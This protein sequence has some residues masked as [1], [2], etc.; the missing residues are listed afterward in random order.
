M[1]KSLNN[2]YNY[3]K[4]HKIFTINNSNNLNPLLEEK[5]LKKIE[6]E[7]GGELNG[8]RIKYEFANTYQLLFE[9]TTDCNLKCKYCAYG[10]LYDNYGIRDKHFLSFQKAKNLIDFYL[11]LRNSSLYQSFNKP[12]GIGFYGG[13]PL[14]NFKIINEIINYVKNIIPNC[15]FHMTTNGTLLN[16]YM[17]YLVEKNF[18]LMISL[19]GNKTNNSYRVYRNGFP[20]FLKIVNNVKALQLKYPNYFQTN[21]TFNTVLHNR[22]S[23]SEIFAFFKKEFNKI[24]KISELSPVGIRDDKKQIYFRKFQTVNKSINLANN[25]QEIIE[26][27]DVDVP[28]RK[29]LSNFLFD[30]SGNVFKTYNDL[31]KDQNT[32]VK[33]PTAT[34]EPFSRKIFLSAE[35]KLYPCERIG[36]LF[37]YGEATESIIDIDFEKIAAR[38]NTYYK[39]IKTQCFK[40]GL[41][42]VCTKCLLQLIS[43]DDNPNCDSMIIQDDLFQKTLAIQLSYLEKQPHLFK[44]IWENYN[45]E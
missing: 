6:D 41:I 24:P 43:K 42:S 35:G 21:V 34:C 39:K 36:Q 9:T 1:E 2:E 14:L 28:R 22:N 16:K 38:H 5:G 44:H 19:D 11:K 3:S 8:N 13:E 27:L 15:S 33:F 32:I 20:S 37:A 26:A 12:F 10:E 7:Y 4:K 25:S 45:F 18:I 40:C 23:V 29:A 17:D 31:F 30:F